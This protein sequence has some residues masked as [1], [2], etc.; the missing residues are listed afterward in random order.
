MYGSVRANSPSNHWLFL[1]T[2]VMLGSFGAS[3]GWA[4]AVRPAQPRRTAPGARAGNTAA[5]PNDQVAPETDVSVPE[6]APEN[7]WI[8][9]LSSRAETDLH[10]LGVPVWDREEE[11]VIGGATESQIAALEKRG[12]EPILTIEDSG[13]GLYVLSHVEGFVMPQPTGAQV[14]AL[15]PTADLYVYPPDQSFEIRHRKPYAAFHAVPRIALPPIK[16]HDADLAETTPSFTVNPLVTQLVNDTSKP[17]WFQDV[18]DLS[19]ENPVIIGGVSRTIMTRYSAAMYPTPA[20]NALASEYLLEKAAGWGYTGTR[21]TYT[22]TDSGCSSGQGTGVW[23]NLVFTI[24]GQVDINQ[25]QQ[26]VFVTH[27]DSLSFNTTEN[28]NYAPGADDAISGGSALIEALRLFRGYGFKNTVKIIFFSGEEQGLCGS[29]A[30]TRQHPM[31]DVWR[32]VNMDQTAYDGN[33]NGWMNCYNWDT[34]NSPQ[35]VALGDAFVQANTDYGPII[36]PAVVFRPTNHMCQTDHCPFWDVGVAAIAV[37]EDLMHNEICPCFDQS[38]SS[39]C[40]DTVTQMDPNHPAQLMFDPDYS[41]PSEKAAI[42]T[43]ASIA[44]P[45]YACPASAP[46]L[47]GTPDDHVAHLS[48][49]S[50]PGVTNYVLERATSCAGP[51]T[52]LVSATGTTYDDTNLTNHTAYAYRLRTCPNQTSAC[53]IV[54]PNS[55]EVVYQPGSA[56]VT[57]DSGDHDAIADN[58]E[59]V[60]VQMNL[61]NDGSI[62]LTGVKLSSV[63][64]THGGVQVVSALPQSVGSMGLGQTAPVS[65]KFYLGRN[66]TLAGCGQSLSFNVGTTSDQTAF[67]PSSF[68]LTAER[69]PTVPLSYGFETNFSG[70]TVTNGTFTRAAGGAPGS[71]AFSLH[72]ENANSVCDAIISPQVI[73]TSQSAM[74]MWV[75]YGIEGSGGVNTAD[76]AV[77]RV[78]NQ[79]TG[80]KTLIVPT[81]AVYTTT[82]NASGLCDNINNLQGYAG[83]A[84][85]WQQ[86][87]FDLASFAGTPI[88]IEV[89]FSTNTSNLG[90]QGFWFDNV[91]ITNPQSCDNQSNACAALPAEVSPDASPVPLTISKSGAN[92]AFRF[93]EVAGATKY[94][95]YGG[96]IDALHEGIYDHEMSGGTCSVIDGT[97]GDGQVTTSVPS[98]N[99]ADN[100]YL[101]AVAQ[102]GAG[103]SVYG[104]RSSG[105]A[106]PLALS[107][108]P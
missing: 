30:Y 8:L 29:I 63:S 26:V 45:L 68:A 60:T 100:T 79:V 70:W 95:I 66:G 54:T 86:A 71:T 57:A 91:E 44:E 101:L 87:S 77:V 56:V 5:T 97:T 22:S 53:I 47:S 4:A 23:Q 105:P 3:S 11:V 17:M 73:P 90:T 40:H 92:L 88:K 21:E 98:G 38:Q 94:N 107:A 1:L 9:A 80:V 74:T 93:S 108:C 34:T 32:V 28:F 51:F 85:T 48:W 46:V 10:E 16:L 72:S 58:C 20:N 103:E 39:T 84:T 89:R 27:H 106:I 33:K 43:V 104:H 61:V 69:N 82:G 64:S 62:P 19:G 99:I 42:A 52:P 31:G 75:N 102:N 78:I 12:I 41:W 81:G 6:T 7:R 2:V 18:K 14:F 96:T 83:S 50:A 49:P 67:T 59:L 24:P 35:S 65:F 13:G 55:P 15:S 37:T 76:R 36:Q 25:H